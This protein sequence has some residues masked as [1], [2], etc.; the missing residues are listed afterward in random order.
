MPRQNFP[1]EFSVLIAILVGAGLLRFYS[2]GHPFYNSDEAAQLLSSL[3]LYQ[4]TPFQFS[5]LASNFFAQI[6]SYQYGFASVTLPFFFYWI[7]STLGIPLREWVLILPSTLAGMAAIV[8]VYVLGRRLFSPGAGLL[9]AALLA[10][11]PEAVTPSRAVRWMS[12]ATVAQG[13]T[14]LAFVRYFERPTRGRAYLASAAIAL[15]MGTNNAFPF[16]LLAVGVLGLMHPR[17]TRGIDFLGAAPRA[18]EEPA[19]AGGMDLS[20]GRPRHLLPPIH[21]VLSHRSFR[22]LSAADPG[23]VRWNRS[24][25]RDLLAGSVFGLHAPRL[26]CPGGCPLLCPLSVSGPPSLSIPRGVVNDDGWGK[27]D[28]RPLRPVQIFA[29][30]GPGGPPFGGGPF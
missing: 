23:E 14:V 2:L 25:W 28:L 7:L 29:N 24:L 17:A 12:Y 8:M 4:T 27:P 22:G 5:P 15:E 30:G 6:F 21:L 13:L 16:T 10:V 1:K 18:A 3:R 9:A 20:G 11:L 26:S 19:S